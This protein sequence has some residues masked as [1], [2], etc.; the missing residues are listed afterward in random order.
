M[1]ALVCCLK[2]TIKSLPSLSLSWLSRLPVLF[3]SWRRTEDESSEDEA[4]I[5]RVQIPISSLH[6][7]SHVGHSVIF[8]DRQEAS[9]QWLR[10]AAGFRDIPIA[11]PHR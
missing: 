8:M 2:L 1:R 9:M 5:A 10:R 4:A 3:L 6:K 11:D 7:T